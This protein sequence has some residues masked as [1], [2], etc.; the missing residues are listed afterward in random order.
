M[1]AAVKNQELI[2]WCLVRLLREPGDTWAAR[3]VDPGRVRWVR[4]AATREKAR[5]QAREIIDSD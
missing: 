5:E 1:S 4:G 3:I 2:G